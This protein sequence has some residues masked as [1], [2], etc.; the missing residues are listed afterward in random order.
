[1]VGGV[2]AVVADRTIR[3]SASRAVLAVE[4]IIKG[5][6]DRMDRQVDVCSDTSPK[7]GRD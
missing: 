5:A 6:L 7:D 4:R 3:M 1:V 2:P